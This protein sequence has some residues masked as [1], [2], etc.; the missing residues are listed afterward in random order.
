M[1]NRVKPNLIF[2]LL[3]VGYLFNGCQSAE[4]LDT[5]PNI[6]YIL[7]DD[8]GYGDLSFLNA[9]SRIQTPELDQLAAAGLHFT[10]AHSGSAV[11]TPTRYGILT[12][13][14]AWR[15]PLKQGVLW[16]YDPPLIQPERLTV[17]EF[18]KDQG[19]ATACIGKWHLGWDWQLNHGGYARDS[20]QGFGFD[21]AGRLRIEQS[22]DFTKTVD[23]GPISHGFDYY[24]GDDVPN[25]PPYTFIENDR[26]L[27]F[28]DQVKPDTMF[29]N[30]GKMSAGWDLEGVMPAITR[31]AVEYIAEKGPN[32]KQK[33][34]FLYFTLTAPHTPIAPADEFKG[35]SQAGA[36]G[37]Y[38]QQVDWTVG[39]IM[40]ALK[41]AQI[42]EN[43]LVIFTSDNGSPARE[44]VN[45][46]GAVSSVLQYGHHPSYHFRGT[47]ADIWEGGHRVPFIV[48]WPDQV[49]AGNL[50]DQTICHT[51][52]LATC[53]AIL[54]Q[55]LPDHTAEDSYDLLPLFLDPGMEQ[56]IREATVH[57]SGN[58]TFAIRKGKWKLILDAGSGGWSHPKNDQALKDGLPPVQLYQMDTDFGEQHNVEAEYPEV[59]QE[60]KELLE[61]YQHSGRSV[62]E[63]MLSSK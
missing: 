12:G 50:S 56:A 10:D 55:S 39:Q 61:S 31:K 27:A 45:M 20:I 33:P 22:V 19:Y 13:R 44:G 26:L 17:A 42:S 14:Y 60:L 54:G 6:V 58:G 18:L 41:T 3:I 11:C 34:F 62:P 28:P 53:A 29:G 15:T 25:F 32:S 49:A 43:T 51:D 59:V 5:P 36:Y 57:H 2:Y 23:N 4:E 1:H 52:F 21:R 8:L 47:K 30:P 48:H 24:F 63:N 9:D 38:V 35:S 46:A 37:D 40:E 16:P 7:A